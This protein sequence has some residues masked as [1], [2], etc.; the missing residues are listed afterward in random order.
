MLWV[1]LNYQ[2]L[3]ERGRTCDGTCPEGKRLKTRLDKYIQKH[4]PLEN[5]M[6]EQMIH[7]GV[8]FDSPDFKAYMAQHVAGFD[9]WKKTQG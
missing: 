2:G 4:G 7:S 5:D 1:V 6:E 3:I 9:S 8:D